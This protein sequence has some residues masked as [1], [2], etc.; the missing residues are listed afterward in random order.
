MVYDHKEGEV[1]VIE[2][3]RTAEEKHFQE[4]GIVSVV[5]A[6]SRHIVR[7]WGFHALLTKS[8]AWSW[9]GL[10]RHRTQAQNLRGCPNIR[11]S[12]KQYFSAVYNLKLTFMS[13]SS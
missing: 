2:R 13:K 4:K 12:S 7:L 1:V 11:R 6:Q 10:G 3:S 5:L 9:V 8:R